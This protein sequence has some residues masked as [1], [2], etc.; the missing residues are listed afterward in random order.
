MANSQGQAQA[1][2]R[3]VEQELAS[4]NA[5]IPALD[6]TAN[7][8][9]TSSGRKTGPGGPTN[10]ELSTFSAER[11]RAADQ[12]TALQ[13]RKLEL[14]ER[15]VELYPAAYPK[16]A[17]AE[18][19]AEDAADRARQAKEDKAERDAAL[20]E[21]Q[22]EADLQAKLAADQAESKRRQT[23]GPAENRITRTT[24]EEE[25]SGGG[26]TTTRYVLS[27]AQEEYYR[28]Q[29]AAEDADAQ[30]QK[31]RREE[32]LR[33]KGLENATFRQ[34]LDAV[35]DGQAKGEFP[36]ESYSE[37]KKQ[38]K[39]DN[40]EIPPGVPP[41]TTVEAG[42]EVKRK[43]TTVVKEGASF[44]T[45]GDKVVAAENRPIVNNQAG[46]AENFGTGKDVSGSATAQP[47]SAEEKKNLKDSTKATQ[48]KQSVVTPTKTPS[49]GEVTKT[50]TGKSAT[51]AKEGTKKSAGDKATTSPDT[52]KADTIVKGGTDKSGT[53][54]KTPTRIKITPNPL[55][56]Y[57]T[58]TY[59]I[60]LHLLTPESY[61]DLAD[62]KEW[63]P[64]AKTLIAGG[65]RWSKDK[66]DKKGFQRAA[67]FK[68]DFYFDGL[69]VESV[70]GLNQQGRGSNVYDFSFNIIEPYGFTLIDRLLELSVEM[71]QPNY[72]TNPYVIQIDFF[73]NN[74][75][76]EPVHPLADKEGRSL[77]K[78]LPCKIIDMQIKVGASGAVYA[79]RASPYNHAAFGETIA[80][81]PANFEI[82]A[83]TV[84]NFFTNDGDAADL[85][86]QIE[87]RGRD[88]RNN[89]VSQSWAQW[90]ATTNSSGKPAAQNATLSSREPSAAEKTKLEEQ[91][92]KNAAASKAAF[93]AKSF[94]G[95][96]NAYQQYLVSNNFTEHPITIKFNVHPE[97]AKA[98]IVEPEKTSP[99]D[100]P[101]VA[102]GDGSG[103]ADSYK[104][105]SKAQ[106]SSSTPVSGFDK[107]T[108]KFNVNAG[109][110][111]IELVNKVMRSSTYITDQLKDQNKVDKDGNP[112]KWFKIIPK[113]KLTNF[114]V[115][116]ND[117]A[118]E[119]T[120]SIIPY[121][122][123][124]SKH[125]AMPISSDDE[126]RKN[127]RKK[128]SYI[129]TGENTDLIDFSVD[130]NTLFHT[131]VDVLTENS[132][133][134]NASQ[135]SLNKPLE[136]KDNKDTAAAATGQRN[137]TV[138]MNVIHPI[139]GDASAQS[140][141]N[142]SS[143]PAAQ[144]AA[145]VMK[146]VYSNARG[147]MINLKVKIIG[148][149][150]FIKTD[151][152]YYNPA[153]VNYPSPEDTHTPDGSII[154]D[155]GDIFCLVGWKSPSD[156]DQTTGFP[157][158]SKYKNSIF[159]GVFKVVKVSSEFKNGSFQQDIELVRYHDVVTD[160]LGAE[161]AKQR[162][163]ETAVANI[164]KPTKTES[165]KET[166]PELTEKS[167]TKVDNA[168]NNQ[169]KSNSTT[170]DDAKNKKLE[171][172]V[173]KGDTKT[174]EKSASDN[175]GAKDGT[176]PNSGNAQAQSPQSDTGPKVKDEGG[177]QSKNETPSKVTK[178]LPDGV[179]VDAN[180]L[181]IYRDVRFSANDNADLQA[182]IGAIDN[183]TK[184]KTTITDGSGNTRNVEF[185]GSQTKPAS[186][187]A[188]IAK[189]QEEY[190][191]AKSAASNAQRRLDKAANG[192]YDDPA[193]PGRRQ[194]IVDGNTK[195][196]NEANAKMAALEAQ[197]KDKGAAP[198]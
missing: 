107:N 71:N 183:G 46:I 32:Y 188:D 70:I 182:K 86:K 76:G 101:M 49:G 102:V 126:I 118:C 60:S 189:I 161:E 172:V 134:T 83:S 109:D 41:V 150:D 105:W 170:P 152:V 69:T 24:T 11:R 164:S 48:T 163:K 176:T 147:D 136:Q 22:R 90:S 154:T 151:D 52:K 34:K 44:N 137:Q 35:R 79:C 5:Q 13:N 106:K 197:L 181:Y 58:Y 43:E 185:D 116:R 123:H 92:K 42:E 149:P 18:Q 112:L 122:Y 65:G 169:T 7:S 191:K 138:Q 110:Q 87:D 132:N 4:I 2:L 114:D 95:A 77:T 125:P 173:E 81:A 117:W 108:Q 119:I 50:S 124:N 115:V 113:L 156:M 145:N 59:S 140:G 148:D 27:P 160:V 9:F 157:D 121:A 1:E 61:N 192:D 19:A 88:T 146:S 29:K 111:I 193:E 166:K 190:E 31:Q 168:K 167:K 143:N 162:E 159:D 155:R 38:F 128:Y 135:D 198:R 184:V 93:K 8:S 180:G 174:Q 91:A 51:Q 37:N 30:V 142:A 64:K 139:A 98:L 73:G 165:K 25:V 16:Q 178:N 53:G 26:S 6:K 89:E 33:S 84:G 187:D 131:V 129:Y 80:V 179:T 28:K 56:A 133:R 194:K 3:Q 75:A 12:L 158:Y 72:L 99:K 63:L 67:Q 97:I 55:H 144:R 23:T 175:A 96:Y 68:D 177:A 14:E 78:Y 104:A 54:V 62:G 74:D 82:V 85:A 153:N 66:T 40:P 45:A 100:A 127:L 141:L 57:A 47:L 186:K 130:F 20:R 17:A 39:K 171:N 120:Y 94:A 36:E 15:K 21:Q 10:E 195:S 103:S 196:L